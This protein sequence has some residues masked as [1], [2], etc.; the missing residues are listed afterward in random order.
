M[1]DLRM[2]VVSEDDLLLEAFIEA[3]ELVLPEES[4]V[5]LVSLSG[6]EVASVLFRGRPLPFLDFDE[7]VQDEFALAVV[8]TSADVVE[9]NAD[10]IYSFRCP[11][12]G[13]HAVL[14]SLH[15]VAME[16]AD[17]DE[18]GIIGLV[19]PHVQV[20]REI[21][22]G[23]DCQS[24]DATLLHPVSVYGRKG[25]A[26]LATQT[27]RMLNAQ[28]LEAQVFHTRIP[29]NYFPFVN[30]PAGNRLQS[31]MN[32]QLGEAF[33]GA[34][35]H[36]EGVQMPVFHGTGVI[37]SVILRDPVDAIE[38]RDKWAGNPGIVLQDDADF[39]SANDIAN[40]SSSLLLG[41]LVVSSEGGR[42]F[43]CWI[44]FDEVKYSAGVQLMSPVN[45][46]LKRHL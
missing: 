14:Q 26:E 35:V 38:L 37:L 43:R 36:M 32:E 6:E 11:V 17:L 23:M 44:L 13:Y 46:L 8:L 42:G 40:T 1:N 22:D 31:L 9:K 20:I 7:V 16:H 29:F 10:W 28:S 39:F 25:V 12:I 27:V 45:S 15:P 4:S 3:L 24:I 33:P 30:G 21:L 34:T 5:V 19:E 18:V 2:V 41:N